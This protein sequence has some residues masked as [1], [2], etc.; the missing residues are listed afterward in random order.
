MQISRGLEYAVRGLVRLASSSQPL[1]LKEIAKTEKIPSAY[2][3]KIM[4][5]LVKGGI[6]TSTKGKKGGYFLLKNPN[7]IALYDLYLLFEKK[8]KL[9]P[10]FN[11]DSLCS[12]GSK[13]RQKLVWIKVEKDVIDAF[14]KVSLKEMLSK[15]ISRRKVKYERSFN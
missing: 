15:N 2:L 6:V 7:Q 10:C 9:L 8:E 13:C 5:V 3:A 12:A 4:R 11:D 1:S 14:K